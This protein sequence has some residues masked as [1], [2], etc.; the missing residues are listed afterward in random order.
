[1]D[2]QRPVERNLQSANLPV[3]SE[4]MAGSPAA[5]VIEVA[6]RWLADCVFIGAEE[7]SFIEKIFCGDFVA[8][9][10]SRAE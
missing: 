2:L 4:I 5:D 3:T 9:V 7:M 1:M 6:R 10:A 8:C